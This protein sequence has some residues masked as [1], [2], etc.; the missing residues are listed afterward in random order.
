MS[1]YAPTFKIERSYG[2]GWSVVAKP[3]V[4]PG[5]E[6]ATIDRTF[7]SEEAARS[8]IEAEG[9]HWAKTICEVPGEGSSQH[10]SL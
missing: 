7:P 3:G 5:D 10:R 9:Q 2:G 6:S 4:G 8:W 1:N